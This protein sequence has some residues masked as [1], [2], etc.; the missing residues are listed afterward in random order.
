[1]D[2][3]KPPSDVCKPPSDVHKPPLD[4]HKPLSDVF[5]HPSDVVEPRALIFFRCFV[6]KNPVHLLYR[7]TPIPS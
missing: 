6:I 1:M 4:M 3:C 7:V 5:K 2:V